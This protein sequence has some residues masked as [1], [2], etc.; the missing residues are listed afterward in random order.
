MSDIL[1]Q[2]G[3]SCERIHND[4]PISRGEGQNI[5]VAILAAALMLCC[6]ALG[7]ARHF[8]GTR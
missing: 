8:K 1:K 6:V 7:I 4:T 5:A 2:T 3:E